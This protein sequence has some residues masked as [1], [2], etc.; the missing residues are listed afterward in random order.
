VTTLVSDSDSKARILVAGTAKVHAMNFSREGAQAAL[1]VL[2]GELE[3]LFTLEE[4]TA[5]SER[6]LGLDPADVGGTAAKGSFAK[7]LAERCLEGDRVDALVDAILH[8][9]REVDPRVRDAA[10][11]FGRDEPL[12]GKV[13]GP[14]TIEKKVGETPSAIVYQAQRDDGLCTLKV[15]RREAARDRRAVQR[16][17]TANRIL[18]GV[19]HEG[20]PRNIDAGELD[21]GLAWVAYEWIEGQTLAQRLGKMGPSHLNEVRAILHGAL[22]ALSALHKAGI[23]HGD[24][25]LD[26]VVAAKDETGELRV[27]LVDFATDRLWPRAATNGHDAGVSR[28]HAGPLAIYG[29]PETIAPEVARGKAADPRSDVY[30]F[31]AIAYALLTGKP[32]FPASDAADALVAHLSR[33]P[34]K[35]S[36]VAPRGW[37]NDEI[38]EWLLSLLAKDPA[39][40]PRDAAAAIEGLDAIGRS[41]RAVR[42][43]NAMPEEKLDELVKALLAAPE[44][45]DA[46]LALDHSI[47]EGADPLKVGE[48][49][50]AAAALIEAADKGEE[51]KELATAL[52]YRAAR[53]LENGAKDKARAEAV[54]EKL[55]AIDPGDEIAASALEEVRRALGKH[56]AIVEALLAR[57]EAAA[58]GEDRARPLAEIGRI[59]DAELDDPDQAIVAYARALCETPLEAEYARA[60]ERLAG[61][62]A[63]R[64]RE[65]LDTI[66]EGTKSESLSS[67]ERTTLLA[68]AGR[69]Y[70][71]KLGRA[72]TALLAYQQILATDPANEEA[73]EG[74]SSIYRRAQQWPELATLLLARAEAAVSPPKRRDLRTEAAELFE[75]KLNDAARAK[76]LYG[77]VLAEEPG[78]A[79]A[80]EALTRIAER[81]GDSER[82][83]QLLDQ[84]AE[85]KRGAERAELLARIA[86]V[87]EDSREDLAEATRRYEAVLAI[88]PAHLGALK[89]LDRIYNRTGRY[90]ELLENLE[91]QVDVAATPRQ[92]INLWERIA[93]L[94]DE[95]FLDHEAA[96]RALEQIL[97]LD[98]QHDGALTALVRHYRALDRWDDVA[99]LLE[100]HAKTTGDDARRVELLAARARVLAEQIG[101]PERATRAYEQVLE[102][103]P[104]HAGALEALARLREIQ[105]DAH[106][107]LTAIEALAAKATTPEAKAEQWMRAARLLEARGDKDGAIERYKLALDANPRDAAASASLRQAYAAR[108]DVAGVVGLVER[109]LASAE[110]DLAK[111]RL[112]GELARIYRAKMKD[113]R[114]AAESA[115]TAIDLDATNADGLIVLGDIAYECDRYLEA[116]RHFE[117]LLSRTTS[118]SR[119]D[120]VRVLVR[121]MEAF[122]KSWTSRVSQ[123]S[124][125]DL[126]AASTTQGGSGAESSPLSR[127]PA[128][129]NH[130]RML[131]AIEAL[132]KVAPDDVDAMLSVSKV[133]FEHGDP[134]GAMQIHKD[135]LAKYGGDLTNGERAEALYRLGESARRVEE[136]DEAIEA[137]QESADLDPSSA[138]PLQSLAWV[139]EARGDWKSVVRTK[140]KRLEV[141]SG[142]ERFDLLLEA[143]DVLLAKLDD[144]A[145]ASKMYVAALEERPDD[146]KLLT[147]LM[148]LYSEEKDWAKLVDVVLRLA[149][150]VE[151]P[152][153]RA[154]Y[155]QTAAIVS[156]R[157]LGEIDQAIEYYD[158]V[159]DLDPTLSKA[160]DEAVELRRQK[161]D[162]EGVEKLLNRRLDQAKNANDRAAIVKTLDE[163]GALYQKFL[164]EPELA[165]DAY[166]AAQA[167][168]PEDRARA[169]TL[170]ELYA[171]DV[172]QYLDKAVRAQTVML[173]KNPYRVESYKLLRRLYTESKKA[174]PAWCLCQALTVLNLAEPDEERFYRRHRADN[175][176]VAQA[177]CNEDD[178]TDRLAHADLDPLLTRIF[179]LIQPTIVRVRTPSLES[180]GYDAKYAIDT[181]LHPYPVSQTLYYAQ[182]V[183]GLAPPL[184][185]Q[186]PNDA[187][188]LGF[189]HAHTPAVVLGRAAF[190]AQVTTQ[191]MAFVAGRHLAYY[192]P[193]YY[194]RHLV[195]TGTGLKAWL[196]AAIKLCV[197][198]F[199]IAGDIQGQ[200]GEA[201]AAMSADF[202]GVQREKLASHVSKLLQAGGALDLKKWVGAIDLTADRAGMLLAHD[203]QVSTEVVRATE[204]GASIPVK[205]RLKELV[206]FSVSEEYFA[207]R[208]K[209]QIRVDS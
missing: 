30:A 67:T 182:G 193:G 189:L 77:A 3:R 202:Q 14:F 88:D 164:G 39:M 48:A 196:F 102:L 92:K 106:A 135:L 86:E 194:V 70:D 138:L 42:V 33:E 51:G 31:G 112:H 107:A 82:L 105:G 114:R 119:Q 192:R 121:F 111:A 122:G 87:Y 157:Q 116:S 162:H 163:L 80:S 145:R 208:D 40:R 53:V 186:N 165:I 96:A 137:L 85:T 118:L 72:D 120:A 74:L 38:D 75:S 90:K 57:A 129:A 15:L 28:G 95:E 64:W 168:D 190:E 8:A 104:G 195:P 173:R 55:V 101:S 148:Q 117:P 10:A 115:R 36:Q 93:A 181:S 34:A 98:P 69:W 169:E 9:R 109:E 66:T 184:V 150:F 160:L 21:G 161:G 4:M 76:E 59:C 199:P 27:V 131:A 99:R 26:S 65:T 155:M 197:P 167:F 19:R 209:L 97:A 134:R 206:L 149:D 152:K 113:D 143:G 73:S 141:A 153:Q 16:F 6:L 37:V 78:H 179:A 22:D 139:Y 136:W 142:A 207:L 44:D 83:V 127:P 60:I 91:R 1:D 41:V 49:F 205:E 204:D 171:S 176:A 178:W 62:N 100:R 151:D 68:H 170:A 84:R 124:T 166:E 185:F 24:L 180:L 159:L 11:L 177:T 140:V 50:E 125:T 89:G 126:A 23:A 17:L 201:M 18:A 56:E 156:H 123:P 130:P 108:G 71:Q 187:G 58:P 144:R 5:M 191:A 46:A 188:G 79:K 198:Q 174:D 7:A 133:A 63:D 54:Y 103:A 43:A 61:A 200:V 110:G 47:E 154:K 52:L 20:L 158:R 12:G 175:A 81:E 147:K 132:T 13:V 203:L 183:L 45:T 2:R 25:K 146:R 29:S 32:P 94:H 128:A 35:P 172:K